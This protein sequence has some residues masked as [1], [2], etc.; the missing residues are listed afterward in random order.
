MDFNNDSCGRFY[1]ALDFNRDGITT[2]SDL[3]LLFKSCFLIPAKGI[4]ELLAAS[5]RL[6]AFFEMD[7][8]TG[9]GGG[10]VVFSTLVWL[11]VFSFIAAAGA[12]DKSITK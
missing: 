10:G 4:A 11:I 9:E 7:C 3:W 6:A 5:P 1:F 8:M 12:V 2:I